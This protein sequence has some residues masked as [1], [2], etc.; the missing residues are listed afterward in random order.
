M[1]NAFLVLE[2]SRL[3]ISAVLISQLLTWGCLYPVW[4]QSLP[5]SSVREEVDPDAF[6]PLE[7]RS[8]RPPARNSQTFDPSQ[9][10][11][12]YLLGPGDD[13]RFDVFNVPELTNDESGNRLVTD[14]IYR[15]L[16]DGTISLPW[17]GS[18]YVTGMSLEEAAAAVA[19]QYEAFIYDPVVTL[20]LS[21]PRP[22][23]IAVA[24]QV[25]APGAYTTRQEGAAST[26][27][28][29]AELR[30]VA[31][32]IQNAGGITQ[33]A[34]IRNIELIR[35][36]P[37]GTREVIPINFYALLVDGD[38]SQNALLR[39]G[40]TVFVPRA[41]ALS[42]EEART[43]ATASFAQDFIEVAVVGEVEDPGRI[44]VDPNTTLNQAILAAGGFADARAQTGKVTFIRVNPNG[45]VE[46]RDIDVDLATGIDDANN[47][48][49]RENDIVLVSRSG[50]ARAS[51]FLE[52]VGT[53]AGGILDPINGI[54]NIFRIFDD[55]END[56]PD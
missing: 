10:I 51:D 30:T 13:V 9:N 17:I 36:Q 16:A 6:A 2:R 33:L 34:D 56:G 44:E 37:D 3:P 19:R 18:V 54:L 12:T 48:P 45:T 49:L 28:S 43:L 8:G 26:E 32:A 4:A 42:P 5:E 14:N 20:S 24:G 7:Q 50:V 25:F 52:L 29:V 39:D 38:Q 35:P 21:A 53:A 27:V 23:R 1:K 11:P 15:V 41:E 55:L 22:I 40:D 47:P 46:K 31:Q